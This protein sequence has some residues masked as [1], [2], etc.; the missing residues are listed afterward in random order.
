MTEP[1]FIGVDAGASKTT[2]LVGDRSRILGRGTA[3]PG[4]PN[5]V[6]LDGHR[7]AVAMALRVAFF[8]AGLAHGRSVRRVWLGVAGSE[9]E[10]IRKAIAEAIR[11]ELGADEIHVS[12]DAALV[13]PAAGCR[14]GIALIAG[15]GSSAYGIGPDGEVATV[16]GWGYLIGDEGSGYELGRLGLRAVSQAADGRGQATSLTARAL[17]AL[18]ATTIDEFRERL[19][20]PA[21]SVAEIATLA[22]VVC[23]AADDGDAVARRLVVDAAAALAAI[24]RTCAS[25][26]HLAATAPGATPVD[27]IAAGGIVQAGSPVLR[28]LVSELGPSHRVR[29]LEAEPAL[30]ALEL[31]RHPPLCPAEPSGVPARL[32]A[33]QPRR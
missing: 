4:N 26:V 19:Y 2:C 31:A 15:T 17:T 7:K 23:R 3:G 18:G 25:A 24:V 1:I 5:V 28:T 14:V 22:S 33:D 20:P 13:L 11:D 6:G 12:H 21:P 27:V 32:P 29:P 30:G 16:G 10:T 8:D 9:R